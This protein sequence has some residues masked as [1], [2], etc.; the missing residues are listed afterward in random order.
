MALGLLAASFTTVA[1]FP[2]L[3]RTWRTKSASDLS[4]AMMGLNSAG[5]F[6]WLIYGLWVHDLPVIVADFAA[7]TLV[8]A[9]LVLAVRYRGRRPLAETVLVQDASAPLDPFSK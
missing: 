4:L 6:L 9:V 7:L 1:F 3:V 5:T 2:Q 8:C